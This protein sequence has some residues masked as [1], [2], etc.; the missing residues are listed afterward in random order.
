MEVIWD[1]TS[2]ADFEMGSGVD[3]TKADADA[4]RT[5]DRAKDDN[6]SMVS[7]YVVPRYD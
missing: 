4:K 2:C 7:K 3:G 5:A 6:R 1:D